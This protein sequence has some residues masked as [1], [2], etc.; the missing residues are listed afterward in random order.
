MASTETE[1]QGHRARSSRHPAQWVVSLPPPQ[2]TSRESGRGARTTD[3]PFHPVLPDVSPVICGRRRVSPTA[4]GCPWPARSSAPGSFI[5]E[6]LRSSRQSRPSFPEQ[7]LPLPLCPA[8]ARHGPHQGQPLLRLR[9]AFPHSH[10]GKCPPI[11]KCPRSTLPD[12]GSQRRENGGGVG[13]LT[14]PGGRGD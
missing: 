9:E 10:S 6:T 12:P 4:A 13:G 1:V 11:P 3:C 2:P 14:L 8:P 7:I 5:T